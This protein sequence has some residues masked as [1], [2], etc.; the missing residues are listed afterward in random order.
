MEKGLDL[1]SRNPV[2]VM[3]LAIISGFFVVWYSHSAQV[4]LRGHHK[5]PKLTCCLIVIES[6]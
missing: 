3:S 1:R 5:Y 6:S 4:V 2:C